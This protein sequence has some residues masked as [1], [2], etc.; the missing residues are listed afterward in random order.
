MSSLSLA[1][2]RP[3]PQPRSAYRAFRSITTRWADNDV[4]GHVNNVV[5]Y[6]F[7]DTAVNQLLIESGLL[8]VTGGAVPEV[9]PFA[10]DLGKRLEQWGKLTAEL[11]A[12]AMKNPDEVG[13]AASDE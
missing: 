8:D 7:I 2:D 1:P 5:Y 6:A 13:A 4:Y 12:A 3:A 10:A 11:G 9:A